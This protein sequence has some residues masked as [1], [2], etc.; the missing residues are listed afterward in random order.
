[1]FQS[2]GTNKSLKVLFFGDIVG[3]P[4][5]RALKDSMVRLVEKYGCDLVIANCENAAGGFGL[6]AET[7][8]EL[9]GAGVDILTSGNHIWDKREIIDY[10]D[11]A[12]NLLRPDNY[13]DSVPG[14]GYVTVNTREGIKVCVINLMGRVFMGSLEDPFARAEEILSEIKSE[15]PITVLDFHGEDTREKVSLA[16]FLDGRMSAVIGTHSHIQ[17]ADERV[18]PGGTAYITDAGMTGP[19]D[20]VIGVKKERALTRFL[21]S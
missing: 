3:K 13:P 6:T 9:F 17:T 12:P 19:R 8:E 16:Y 21:T 4:G 5:R 11:K 7:A 15:T 1:M 18:L 20:S 14:R 10:M 2:D